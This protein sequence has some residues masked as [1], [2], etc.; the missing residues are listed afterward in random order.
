M[1]T[2]FSILAIVGI[3]IAA[4]ACTQPRYSREIVSVYDANG[5][6]VSTTVTDKCDQIDPDARMKFSFFEEDTFR[7]VPSAHSEKKK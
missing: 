7:N 4:T 2:V 1:R 6:L 5:E 3:T